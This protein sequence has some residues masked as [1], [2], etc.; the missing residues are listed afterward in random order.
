MPVPAK[1][2]VKHY[3]GDDF[4]YSFRLDQY[5]D[6]N[7]TS[8][9]TQPI[10]MTGWTATVES[11]PDVAFTVSS[12]DATGV[13]NVDLPAAETENEAVS[14]IEFDVKLTNTEP[15]SRTYIKVTIAL[16]DQVT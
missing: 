13:I 10:D 5:I 4:R 12:P 16:D 3:R 1:K 7:D 2:R 6:P 8:L 11:D 15:F 14:T 9:G